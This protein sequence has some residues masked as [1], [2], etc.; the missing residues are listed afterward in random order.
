M[1]SDVARRRAGLERTI[2]GMAPGGLAVASWEALAR[3][4]ELAEPFAHLLAMDPPPVP[5]GVDLLAGAPGRGFAELAWGPAETEFTL[6][7]WRHSLGVRAETAVLWRELSARGG[8]DGPELDRALAGRGQPPAHRRAGRPDAARAGRVRAGRGRRRRPARCWWCPPNGPRWSTRRPSAPTP[9][10]W[11]PWSGIWTPR[12]PGPPSPGRPGPP[13]PGLHSDHGQGRQ[14]DRLGEGPEGGGSGR[15]EAGP[16]VTP[17][18]FGQGQVQ[19][20]GR[21]GRVRARTRRPGQV[22]PGTANGDGGANGSA[23]ATATRERTLTEDQ[24]VL[25]GDLFAVVEEHAGEA[26]EEID[27]VQGPGRLRLRLRAPLRPAPGQ[28]RGLHRAPRR[29]GQDLRRHAAG[30]G[31][32]VRRPAARHRRGHQRLAGGG[33]GRVR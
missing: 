3:R 7:Y 18:S 22:P 29:R 24:R 16:Q 15:R 26:T 31:H 5:E 30:H 8:L 25:L 9:G 14:D 33:R 6:A 12:P 13:R 20:L 21:R 11:P 2:A 17:P 32:A 28:R 27:R 19:R 1:V 4:P 23:V 10:A